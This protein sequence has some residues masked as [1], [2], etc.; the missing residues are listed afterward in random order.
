M[1][2]QEMETQEAPTGPMSPT[3]PKQSSQS[4]G[5]PLYKEPEV[6]S[7]FSCTQHQA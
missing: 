2:L 3:Q 4:L 1:S 5:K 6:P 7:F